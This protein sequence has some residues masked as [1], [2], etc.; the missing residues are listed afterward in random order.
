[1]F[2]F[3][4]DNALKRFSNRTPSRLALAQRVAE[5]EARKR[6]LNRLLSPVR[7]LP[8]R[9]RRSYT[10]FSSVASKQHRY[11]GDRVDEPVCSF[12]VPISSSP[13]RTLPTSGL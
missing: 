11:C 6:D 12:F 8:F 13:Y 10:D 7:E 9:V 5:V 1:M 2:L 3:R 4:H